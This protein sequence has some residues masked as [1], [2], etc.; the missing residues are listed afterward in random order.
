MQPVPILLREPTVPDV[1][2]LAR[3]HWLAWDRTY[4]GICDDGWLD[5]LSPQVFEG[6]HAARFD[7][8]GALDAREPFVVAVNP[9]RRD[10]LLGF[11]RAGPNRPTTPTGDPIPPCRATEC[12]AELYAIYVHPEHQ[13]RGIGSKMWDHLLD[14][15]RERGHR[16]MCLWV[17]SD[18]TTAR[19]FYQARGG[20][21]AGGAPITLGD[22]KYDQIAYG[23]NL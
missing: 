18:N 10:E 16:S 7:P 4:R 14:A 12:S 5:T 2:A 1:P 9:D 8:N 22:R 17:L 21:E 19:R 6:Y 15:L 13:G 3:L 20:A 23:W 11:A